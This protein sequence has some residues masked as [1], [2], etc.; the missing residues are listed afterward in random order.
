MDL[1][2]QAVDG[3]QPAPGVA[4][5]AFV[6]VAGHRLD[7]GRVN[8]G[9]TT[10]GVMRVFVGVLRTWFVPAPPPPRSGN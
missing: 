6:P 5:T 1:L 4:L 9:C 2:G 3:L 10:L 7:A 8:Q